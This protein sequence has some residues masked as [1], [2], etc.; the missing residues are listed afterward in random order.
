MAHFAEVN[1][2][3][4]VQRVIVVNNAVLL[5]EQDIECDWLGEQFCQQL[6]GAHTRWVQTSYNGG[7]Y[8]NYAGI[9]YTFDPYRSA[10]I[11]PQP[12]PSWTLD[13]GTCRWQPPIPYPADGFLYNWDETTKKWIK[14]LPS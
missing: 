12:F 13:E 10:F 5:N 1:N 6:Y 2:Q 7:K 4:I 3:W 8:K 11:E 9:G 14:V